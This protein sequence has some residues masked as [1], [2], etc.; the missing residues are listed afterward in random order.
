M[1][2]SLA[3]IIYILLEVMGFVNSARDQTILMVN[4]TSQ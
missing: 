2:V 3:P 1:K 4:L